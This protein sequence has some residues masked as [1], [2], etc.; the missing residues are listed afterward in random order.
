MRASALVRSMKRCLSLVSVLAGTLSAHGAASARPVM[1]APAVPDKPLIAQSSCDEAKDRVFDWAAYWAVES[2]FGHHWRHLR[3][4]VDAAAAPTSAS[5]DEAQ[6]GPGSYTG[7]NVQERGVDEAD[8]V[9]TDGKFIYSVSGR[10]VVIVKSWP[11]DRSHVVARHEM[12]AQVTPQ[13]LFLS[14]DRLVVLSHVYEQPAMTKRSRIANPWS[15]PDH[16]YGTRMTVLDIENRSRPRVVHEA[17]IEGYAAQARMIG[18]D[19][20]LVANA[21]M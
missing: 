13:Q 14:G 8:M 17:D 11:A 10:E 16:F 4:G 6:S 9:K 20:Y 12:P 5:K 18:D 21:G 1:V 15:Q 3:G 19:V 7:T 2:R